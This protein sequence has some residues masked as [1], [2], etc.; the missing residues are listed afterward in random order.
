MSPEPSENHHDPYKVR[1]VIHE[2]EHQ[3][4]VELFTEDIGDTAGQPQAEPKEML[5]AWMEFLSRGPADP[6]DSS[7]AKIGAEFF[8][9]LFGGDS[10]NGRMWQKIL[11]RADKGQRPVRLLI[12]TITD[13]LSHLPFG[14]LRDP[15]LPH[16]LFEP[17]PNRRLI[18][19]VR[20]VRQCSPL[21]LTL[22][23]PIRI[24]LAVASP[25]GA[26]PFPAADCLLQLARAAAGPFRVLLPT[27]T[28]ARP[29]A[30]LV[31]GAAEAWTA[32]LFAPYCRIT[33][34]VLE[35][36]LRRQN[37]CDLLHL[38]SHCDQNRV[39]LC[40]AGGGPDLVSADRLATW[41]ARAGV[42]VAFLQ[43]CGGSSV[44]D[45][46]SFGGVA[47]Q[48][49]NPEMGD[50]AAVIASPFPLHAR[51][52][53]E[54]AVAFY[55][56]L[57]L[58]NHS[59]DTAL[60]RNLNEFNW[61]WA[62]L[63][64]WARP[65]ALGVVGNPFLYGCPYKGLH[66]FEVSDADIFFGREAEVEELLRR[67]QGEPV[68]AVVGDS[69]S[70]KSSL[71]K[72]GLANAVRTGHPL[73]LCDRSDWR[74]VVLRPG[75]HPA[76]A[77]QAALGDDDGG[78]PLLVMVDQF[79]EVFTLQSPAD[80]RQA[81]ATNL[82][83]LFHGV[84]R[85][86]RLMLGLRGEHLGKAA[87]LLR[88]A[89]LR[90]GVCVLMSP[91]N[92]RA[93]IEEPAR[94]RG[95]RFQ[96][97][98]ADG[99][100]AHNQNLLDRLLQDPL[101]RAAGTA[102]PLPL[103]ELALQRLW[104]QAMNHSKSEFTHAAF[105]ELGKG[106]PNAAGGLAGV[107]VQHAEQAYRKLA[108]LGKAAQPM[109]QRL[110]IELVKDDTPTRQ[111]R[112]L[113]SLE[114]DLQALAS[115]TVTPDD[116]VNRLVGERLLTVRGSPDGNDSQVDI[117][118]EVLISGWERLRDW[119]DR[120]GVAIRLKKKLDAEAQE[121]RNDPQE[122]Q[123]QYRSIWLEEAEELLRRVPPF[124]SAE[125]AD[126]LKACRALRDKA[127]NE[128]LADQQ[129]KLDA[130]RKQLATEKQAREAADQYNQRLR[131]QRLQLVWVSAA[132]LVAFV[133][134]AVLAVLAG[135]ARSDA[136]KQKNTVDEKNKQLK[137]A[138]NKLE[139]SIETERLQRYA[140]V[141]RA[142]WYYLAETNPRGASN[143]FTNN[144]DV[145]STSVMNLCGFE[146]Y[147]V[148]RQIEEKSTWNER[149]K[150]KLKCVAYSTKG[151]LLAAGGQGGQFRVWNTLTHAPQ[152]DFA[153]SPT[154]TQATG[155]SPDGRFLA[156]AGFSTDG[157]EIST[158]ELRV[159]EVNTGKQVPDIAFNHGDGQFRSLAF[160]PHQ[161][162]LAVAGKFVDPETGK[163]KG[164]VLLWDT[165]FWRPHLRGPIIVG[166][167]A[168]AVAFSTASEQ[169]IVVAAVE[170]AVQVQFW[171][172][173]PGKTPAKTWPVAID[174][175][176]AVACSPKGLAV[177]GVNTSEVSQWQ[178]LYW[179]WQ[180]ESQ[181][182]TVVRLPH[183]ES[184]LQGLAFSADGKTLAAGASASING[185]NTQGVIYAWPVPAF[186]ART[187]RIVPALP[188]DPK[189]PS[190]KNQDTT[191]HAVAFNGDHALAS[192]GEDE[193]VRTW[194]VRGD[195]DEVVQLPPV[196]PEEDLQDAD[197]GAQRPPEH[198]V[199]PLSKSK[200]VAVAFATAR[201][202]VAVG[203][204]HPSEGAADSEENASRSDGAVRVLDL[205]HAR[206]LIALRT[207]STVRAVAF[208]KEDR[209][210][211]GEASGAV[212]VCNLPP[213]SRPLLLKTRPGKL[214]H[215]KPVQ[216]LAFVPS[217]PV[218]VSAGLDGVR[219]WD[220]SKG[221]AEME[222]LQNSAR[223]D[224]DEPTFALA[225]SSNASR[226]ATGHEKGSEGA[227]R[228]ILWD[229]STGTQLNS[230]ERIHAQVT[231]LAFSPDG[232]TLAIGVKSGK[233]YFWAVDGKTEP[234][235]TLRSHKAAV[236]TL[237]FSPD[238]RTLVS[239]SNDGT[240]RLWHTATRMELGSFD[241]HESAVYAAV[242]AGE[243]V[244]S[245]TLMTADTQGVLRRWST[246]TDR[247]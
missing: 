1:L 139:A 84:G 36:S 240:V 33:R 188:R 141:V 108:T 117:A 230:E 222:L 135:L 223:K 25:T 39:L 79:E 59:L 185:R 60:A 103:L 215:E 65:G 12:D 6:D 242:F 93:I 194:D 51:H 27:A 152:T 220:L 173:N 43:V 225:V 200:I 30:E 130:E 186:K 160:S 178:V 2:F 102:P 205:N 85:P 234:Q 77:L 136:E 15:V 190:G 219:R 64:V 204:G 35:E 22:G 18:Q 210:A 99:D 94:L 206:P 150:G 132:T 67:L 197:E 40:D 114:R 8:K 140:S 167:E 229:L 165:K 19:F 183:K 208:D 181:K 68:V 236:Y 127:T 5:K 235:E 217:S 115:D 46:G 162:L 75:M 218:L 97:P 56:R 209:V 125:C 89:G 57:A 151:P 201:G 211:W 189:L 148:K 80:E 144:K 247:R 163:M 237:A 227:G 120:D 110:F 155:F 154:H 241:S 129:A 70:G 100:P 17:R 72:A 207:G 198:P 161:P 28:G 44:G 69:G 32:D 159:W 226:L 105:D 49:L 63:E 45:R 86:V 81:L 52:S 149:L 143:V 142:A 26:D 187:H 158:A 11:D 7:A 106:T 231:A 23:Q 156:A 224:F 232:R 116:V 112:S 133:A 53:T 47:Q 54:A 164:R 122:K 119:L 61:S 134:A 37:E 176:T 83:K 66:S 123:L 4:L 233:I 118:H 203:N 42:K 180:P 216:A 184:T 20:I 34:A 3:V 245:L 90:P 221:G 175:V 177:G 202:L 131:R 147:Y 13:K 55:Q 96:G 9:Y 95:F 238:G 170:D 153:G 107:I 41:C 243:K 10:P 98:V 128:K 124:L 73:R 111:P 172:L 14:L 104:Y 87:E 21:Q 169:L 196:P 58:G 171:D 239:G 92:H 109:A 48:L 71:L 145:T 74:V 192:A 179:A 113:A 246:G 191:V 199:Q 244:S 76:T 62:F 193:T 138:N 212:G 146:Y 78:R 213:V 82:G 214:A 174:R 29:L 182:P 157:G 126:Y 228:V 50:L 31:P 24:L 121:W 16:Y 91:A 88:A 168:V 101:L 166:E 137:V 195:D 38:L